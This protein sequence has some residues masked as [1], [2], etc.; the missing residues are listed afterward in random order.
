MME[1]KCRGG[2]PFKRFPPPQLRI[3]E[4]I[5]IK[6]QKGKFHE[7]QELALKQI[8]VRISEYLLKKK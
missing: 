5:Y 8:A 4:I 6:A 3:K 2:K 7:V 1:I